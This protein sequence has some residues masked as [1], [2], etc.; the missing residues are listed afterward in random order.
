MRILLTAL[1]FTLLFPLTA[2]AQSVKSCGS[3]A[4]DPKYNVAPHS[5]LDYCNFYPRRFEYRAARDTLRE[6]LEARAKNYIAP[7]T[8]VLSA[9]IDREEGEWDYL[10]PESA[11]DKKSEDAPEAK[12]P[13]SAGKMQKTSQN[14]AITTYH[15]LWQ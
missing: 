5:P 6:Q 12:A 4:M 3:G 9:Y 14:R 13:E 1:L 11:T 2:Q 8:Q 10:E 7:R 15:L